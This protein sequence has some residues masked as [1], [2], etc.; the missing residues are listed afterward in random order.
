[1]TPE[2][3]KREKD[4]DRSQSITMQTGRKLDRM[5]IAILTVIIAYLLVDRFVLVDEAQQSQGINET[6]TAM[7]EPAETWA[8]PTW[9]PITSN[10]A[11]AARLNELKKEKQEIRKQIIEM[12]QGPE[13][14][15]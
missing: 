4:V 11:V 8:S 13:W 12:L 10:P 14:S 1:M 5:I 3:L 2:G 9:A 15:G 7:T 6:S